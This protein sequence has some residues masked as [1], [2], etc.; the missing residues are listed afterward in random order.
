MSAPQ[1]PYPAPPPPPSSSNSLKTALAAGAIIAS[2]A[3]NGFLLYQVHDLKTDTAKGRDIMQNEIDTI[4]E[5][6][7]VMTATQR[8]HLDDLKEELDVRSRQATQAASQAK[9]E[10]LSY[11]DQQ[12]QKLEAENQKTAD[13]VNRVN[14]DLSTVRQSADS[15]NAKIADVGSDVNGVKTDLASTKTDLQQTK[16][17]LKQVRGDLGA[18]SSLVATNGSQIDEL[19]KRGER[20]IVKFNVNKKTK[21]FQ[22][23]G[24]ISLLLKNTDPKKNKFT[25]QVQADDKLTEKK[26]RNIN[27]PLQFYVSNSLYE[28]VVNTVGK[29]TISGY[30]STPKYQARNN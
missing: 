5:N 9:K 12:A 4:K 24:D 30:L 20:N 28:L 7:T 3:A 17:D 1:Y 6:S 19:I 14:S 13:N 27:E 16:T 15:A 8:K 21:G 26:D 22:K 18:T 29:D 11:A 2:L 23:V 10:A 25:V